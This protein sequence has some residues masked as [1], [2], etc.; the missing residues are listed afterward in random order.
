MANSIRTPRQG[1]TASSRR[2]AE[3][4]DNEAWQEFRLSM[5]GVSTSGKID[6]LERYWTENHEGVAQEPSEECDFCVRVHNY[7]GALNRGGQ[8]QPGTNLGHLLDGTIK[9]YIKK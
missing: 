3:A 9:D 7:I 4:V 2:I 1:V 6:M 5:K 8:L